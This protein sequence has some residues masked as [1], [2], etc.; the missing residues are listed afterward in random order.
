MTSATDIAQFPTTGWRRDGSNSYGK[1]ELYFAIPK[2]VV[3]QFQEGER[4]VAE[5]TLRLLREGGVNTARLAE[6]QHT[7]NRTYLYVFAEAGDFFSFRD[8]FLPN[9][10][11]S[12]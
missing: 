3:R 4:S 9:V 8:K 7:D 11:V 5:T 12:G 10:Q 2:V 1:A 6:A